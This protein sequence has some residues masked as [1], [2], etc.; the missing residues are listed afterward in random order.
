MAPWKMMKKS[1][2]VGDGSNPDV[3]ILSDTTPRAIDSVKYWTQVFKALEHE[4]INFSE[5]FDDEED[6]T[7]ETNSYI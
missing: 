4:I 1:D 3:D 2:V 6:D 7:H 5:D